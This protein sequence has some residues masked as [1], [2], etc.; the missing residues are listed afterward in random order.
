M[1][2][3]NN[4]GKGL[5]KL[6]YMNVQK[7]DFP[8]RTDQHKNYRE[9][10]EDIWTISEESRSK[11]TQTLPE[12]IISLQ[13]QGKTPEFRRGTN[14]GRTHGHTGSQFRRHGWGS[15]AGTQRP[16]KGVG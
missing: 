12:T 10:W 6:V 5:K 13:N 1:C 9:I 3:F 14:H 7:S 11:S 2:L 8:E 16:Q 15:L 4:W